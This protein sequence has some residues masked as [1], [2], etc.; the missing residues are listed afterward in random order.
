MKNF[1][2]A[3]TLVGAALVVAQLV[4][5]FTYTHESKV[6][7]WSVCATAVVWLAT[8]LVFS[9]DRQ[10]TSFLTKVVFTFLLLTAQS[11]VLGATFVLSETKSHRH[12]TGILVCALVHIITQ[13]AAAVKGHEIVREK[14]NV[15]LRCTQH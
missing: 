5:V 3:I 14:Y 4:L 8:A 9:T 12:E 13:G 1:F 10:P 15:F 11:V 6:L 2:E 7:F